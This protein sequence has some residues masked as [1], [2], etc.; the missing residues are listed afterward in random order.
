MKAFSRKGFTLIELIIVVAII[1]ILSGIVIPQFLSVLDRE[2]QVE[3]EPQAQGAPQRKRPVAGKSPF[4]PPEGGLPLIESLNMEMSLRS[5]SHRLGM[6]VFTR[7]EAHCSGTLNFRRAAGDSNPILLVIPLPEG[8][9]EARDVRLTLT[10]QSD[11]STW[12]PDNLVYHEQRLYWSGNVPDNETLV[13]EFEFVAL[14]REQFEY[15]LPPAR[16]LRLVEI[17]M[18]LSG[19]GSHIIPNHGLQP[20]E[21]RDRYLAWRFQ[22]LVTDRAILLDIPG[23]VS[24][25]GRVLLLVRLMAVAV[26]FFGFGF[27]YLSEPGQLKDF[28]WG[29]FLL[30]ALTYSLYFVIFAVISFQQEMDPWLAM[31]ISAVFSLPLLV[32]HVSRAIHLTFALRRALPLAIFTLGLVINGVYGGFLREYVFIAAA[33]GSIAFFTLTYESWAKGRERY[34]EHVKQQQRERIAAIRTQ[35]TGTV[36][37]KLDD[38]VVAG[39]EAER[40]IAACPQSERATERDVLREQRKPVSDLEKAY[41]ELVKRLPDQ[42]FLSDLSDQTWYETFQQDVEQLQNDI[43]TV[44]QTL[45]RHI[46]VMKEKKE[47]LR[48]ERSGEVYCAACGSASTPSPYC[49]QCGT[50]RARESAC[51]GCG[52]QF[53]LP[54]HALN[55]TLETLT[56]YC[57]RCGEQYDPVKVRPTPPASGSEESS[58]QENANT[59][60]D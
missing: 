18:E 12:D 14:G 10:R 41:R 46:R 48:S 51:R 29:H 45:Q 19:P 22:H 49:S 15:A 21:R 13:A 54:L 33:V 16:Q 34:Q 50:P 40:L 56:L 8:R 35:V 36:K 55:T 5:T 30:L 24:P 42:G 37:Q 6:E 53:F 60:Q 7:Y 26:L 27:W 9:A 39:K 4:R 20:T 17:N 1:A 47:R 2:Q 43:Q 28:R 25:L 31:G 58:E 59:H 57:P 52:A 11:S 23:G 3:I 44:L 32:L 38:T